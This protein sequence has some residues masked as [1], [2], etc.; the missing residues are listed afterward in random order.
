MT[1]LEVTLCKQNIF[2]SRVHK[3]QSCWN[4]I[5]YRTQYGY[6]EFGPRIQNIRYKIASHRASY[7]LS[8][9]GPIPKG[10]CVLHKCDNRKCV[11]PKHLWLGTRS[12]NSKD[13]V[14]KNR[15]AIGI[16]N[17]GGK[18]LNNQQVKKIKSRLQNGDQQKDIAKDFGVSPA[19]ICLI[20]KGRNWKHV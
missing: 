6:G 11:N 4:W 15:S 10:L 12:E 13:M 9:N 20:A 18:K 1:L 14:N 16:K 19:M 5:G 7:M 2:W 8:H 17:G 3:T